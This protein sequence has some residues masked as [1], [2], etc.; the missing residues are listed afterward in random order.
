MIMKKAVFL[1]KDGTLVT[2]VPY[3]ADPALVQ[4][5]PDAIAALQ[6]LRVHGYALI[7]VSNQS[8]IARGYFDETQLQKL[9]TG[10]HSVL[11]YNGL[12]L[13]GFYYCPHHPEGA[14][15]AYAIDCSC[16]KPLPGMLQQAAREL[17]ISL[18]S[19][20]M[21]GDILNDVEAGNRAGCRTVLI[22]NGNETEWIMADYR[23]PAYKAHNLADAAAYIIS[24]TTA[25]N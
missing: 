8:G 1:D 19:S 11:H 24:S 25:K 2:D 15:K 12:H 14:V 5:A 23:T 17:D 18:P 21:V 10:M 9:I 13:D 6:L 20:W 7:V 16:R 4:W 3:N 22:D